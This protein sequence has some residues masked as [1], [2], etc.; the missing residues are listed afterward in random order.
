MV[1]YRDSDIGE[2]SHSELKRGEAERSCSADLLEFNT[3]PDHPV[4]NR[5]LKR[6]EGFWG[7]MSINS[8]LGKR[9]IDG[10]GDT[11]G[12]GNSA[13]VNL[14]STIGSTSGCPGTRKVALVGIA[15]DCGFT[16][17]FSSEDDARQH[18]ITQ[19]NTASSLYER[20]FNI[21]LGIK[22]VITSPSSCPGTA[23]ASAPWNTPCSGSTTI[24]DRL[25]SF[26]KWRGTQEDSNAYWSLFTNCA[27]GSEVGLAWLG[28]LCNSQATTEGTSSGSSGSGSSGSNETVSS[29]NVI[30]MTGNQWQVFAHET[31]HMFGAVHD[32][33]SQTCADASIVNSQQCCP[34]STST[35]DANAKYIMNPSTG[36][37][38]TDFS[39][40]TI[41]NI[42]SGIGRNSINSTCL[43]DNKGVTTISGQTCGNGIVEE[44]EDC[45]CGGTEGCGSNTCCDP[46]TCKFTTGSVCDDS[47]EDCCKGCQFASA[48]TVCRASTGQCDPQEV[49]PGNNSTCPADKTA[50]DGTSCGSGQQCASGQCTSRDSQCKTLMASYTSNNDTYACNS[51]T[52]QIQCASPEF[53]TGVCYEMQQNFLD[54]TECGGGG[55]CRNV[56]LLRLVQQ[57]PYL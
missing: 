30:A 1:V 52:C 34:L 45:D 53:G 16:G 32:C 7:S 19:V 22:N 21:S 31:G 49:C 25:N 28:Q 29:A 36:Q 12:S 15:T 35:C 26:S 2:G 17:S 4:Y 5:V 57:R 46:T 51:Q 13:G 56:S 47:N 11:G 23:P 54:G 18:V 50:N 48:G 44:G 37:G 10:G 14:K 39:P 41:G 24:T 27:T 33:D 9:Q 6:D 8:I 20:S 3:R 43:S 42:C 38:I 40:C 55:K